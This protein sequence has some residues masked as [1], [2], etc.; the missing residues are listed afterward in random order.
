MA[1]IALPSMAEDFNE[2]AKR[3]REEFERYQKKTKKA[4]SDY[5]A[6]TQK[7]Y[8]E[9]RAKIN[10]EFAAYLGKPWQELPKIKP[11]A[12]PVE[13]DPPTPIIIDIDEEEDPL[14]PAPKPIEIDTVITP[15]APAPQPE[16]VVP[17]VPKPTPAPQTDKL[18]FYGTN[19][20]LTRAKFKD[21]RLRNNSEATIASTWNNI[22]EDDYAEFIDDLLNARTKLNLPD[23]G[24]FKLVDKS[25][26]MYHPKPSD[27]H[28]FLMAFILTQSGYKVRLGYDSNNKLFML[29]SARGTVYDRSG[30]MLD[31]EKFYTYE[32]LHENSAKVC[33]VEFPAEQ[34]LALDIKNSPNFSFAPGNIRKVNVKNYPEL[35]LTTTP[36][37]NLID[38]WNDYIEGTDTN[39]E[40]G[41]WAIQGNCPMSEKMKKDLYP[42]LKEKIAGMN[43]TDAANVLLKVAQSFPYGYDIDEWGV[44][45]RTFWVEETWHYPKSDCEDHAIH[46]SRLVRDLLNLDAVLI[47]YPGHLSCAIEITDG[48]ARGDYVTLQGKRYTVCDA[49]CFY[50]PVGYTAPN[51]D[52]SKAI[53]IP[54]RK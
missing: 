6:K 13:P 3:Q 53:L 22:K 24:Y 43:Q 28:T 2:R 16:P 36:N 23:W 21:L 25:L 47:Y 7:E 18:T 14:P 5:D 8:E 32:P 51:Y 41:R 4:F 27:E 31:G 37:K 49:T 39:T 33:Q 52:N 45:D 54:L 10:A 26:A 48:T 20:D 40:Y 46:F 9:Y 44:N 12:P 38:F 17:F 11:I 34:S 15:P 29:F 19:L 1:G 42:A 30:F 35:T 50:S